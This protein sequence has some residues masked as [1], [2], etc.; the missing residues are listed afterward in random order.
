MQVHVP[1]LEKLKVMGIHH[2]ENI[3]GSLPPW[4]QNLTHLTLS[5]CSNLKELFHYNTK[6]KQA[7]C[8]I[9]LPKLKFLKLDYLD[10]LTSLFSEYCIEL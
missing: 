2:V 1:N 7:S 3:W 10:K 4:V 8:L 9:K 6:V 5:F